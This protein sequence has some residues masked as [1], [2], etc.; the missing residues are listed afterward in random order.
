[1]PK[2]L[3]R[4]PR[5]ALGK[6]LSALLPS[7]AGTGANPAETKTEAELVPP[8]FE[9]THTLPGDFEEFSSIPL[10]QILPGEDQPRNAFDLQKLHEL[11]DSIKANG[12]LQP[13]TVYKTGPMQYRL[14]AGERRWRAAA[15]AG[16]TEIPALVRNVEHQKRLELGLIENIQREDL[17]A[18]EIA[19]AFN[20]LAHQH[21]LSHEQIAERTGKE[22][23]TVTNFIRLLRL[24]SPVQNA[25][26]SGEISMGHAR[27][28]LGIA[29]EHLQTSYCRKII[30]EQLSV[31]ETE[32]IVKDLINSAK[33]AHSKLSSPTQTAQTSEPNAID[34]NLR[35]ALDAISA[36]L[37]TKVTLHPKN[38]DS[39][40]LEIEYYSQEDLDRIYSVIV[41]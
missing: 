31:R 28:L 2:E 32:K 21:G 10:D 35:A 36:A 16:L 6:G 34:A 4:N 12:V 18:I 5:K 20:N 19:V 14:I 25:L 1:M 8:P 7:R 41:D 39:G 26:I 11:G 23:S 3:E 9:Q 13:V 38:T 17:N 33:A 27:V 40:R 15:L 29:E 37:G 30:N 22:R 24:S